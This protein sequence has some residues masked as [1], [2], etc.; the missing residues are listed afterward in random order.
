M[1]TAKN[2]IKFFNKLFAVFVIAAIIF[3]LLLYFKIGLYF[4]DKYLWYVYIGNKYYVSSYITY[5][6]DPKD[7]NYAEKAIEIDPERHEA[8]VLKVYSYTRRGLL[9]EAEDALS[10]LKGVYGTFYHNQLGY[11][12]LQQ[13]LINESKHQFTKAIEEY[14]S[15]PG[16][17]TGMSLVYLKMKDYKTASEYL[18]LAESKIGNAPTDSRK[19]IL[20]GR[21][22]A[23]LGFIYQEQG[24]NQKAMEEFK[25]AKGYDEYAV[26]FVSDLIAS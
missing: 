26:D 24:F 8:H 21:I 1:A 23:A 10:P 2:R 20:E 22:H 7:L 18:K 9:S 12:K 17:Y 14:P 25:K 16:G 5:G 19:Q 6:S 13:G 3:S 11:I 15:S 4:T